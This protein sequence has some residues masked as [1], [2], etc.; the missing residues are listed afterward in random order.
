M[1]T[2]TLASA[3]AAA[4]A[5]ATSAGGPAGE[6]AAWAADSGARIGAATAAL[7][8]SRA[9]P[10]RALLNM[11]VRH[12]AM[13]RELYDALAADAAVSASMAALEA[14]LAGGAPSLT[15][16]PAICAADLAV[17]LCPA[18]HD[19]LV[20]GYPA[21]EAGRP[22]VAAWVDAVSALPA[23]AAAALPTGGR[24]RVGGQVDLRASPPTVA[25][26]ADDAVARNAG[27]KKAASQRDSED[28]K[29]EGAAA[30]APAPAPAAA[31]AAAPA[32]AAAAPAAAAQPESNKSLPSRPVDERIALVTARLAALG[33]GGDTAAS[34]R[35]HAAA[36]TVDALLAA[37]GDAPGL[38]AKNL[39]VKAK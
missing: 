20:L 12:T 9:A 17:F 19:A 29:K 22:A 30:P 1:A 33:I 6:L 26:L 11:G 21:L 23:A 16:A 39:F 35:R 7:L 27:H 38:R 28:A 4:S 15:G 10:C 14:R 24:R 31:P 13:Q 37:L 5:E 3:A 32:G 34:M 25:A 36:E 2:S 18:L 8:A